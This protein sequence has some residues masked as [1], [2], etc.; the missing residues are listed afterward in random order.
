MDLFISTVNFVKRQ[1]QGKS[2]ADKLLDLLADPYRSQ[3]SL[4][5]IF[6]HNMSNSQ[7]ALP[8]FHLCKFGHVYRIHLTPCPRILPPK[9]LQLRRIFTKIED[10]RRETC[11][12]ADGKGNAG[13]GG[14]SFENE[15]ARLGGSDW[16]R[17]YGLFESSEDV[18]EYIPGDNFTGMWDL[19]TGQLVQGSEVLTIECSELGHASQYIWICQL[20]DDDMRMAV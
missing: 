2:G 13:V 5:A 14:A 17:R 1:E 19:N 6:A 8:I 20:G 4:C 10:C 9:T 11:P 18:S 15:R 12:S 7:L 16:T 3:V